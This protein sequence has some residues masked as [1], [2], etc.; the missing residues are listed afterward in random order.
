MTLE[1][2]KRANGEVAAYNRQLQ[3]GVIYKA[4]LHWFELEKL[5]VVLP[6]PCDAADPEP[7]NVA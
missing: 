3:K 7:D 1:E 4:W 5:G 6:A 2:L